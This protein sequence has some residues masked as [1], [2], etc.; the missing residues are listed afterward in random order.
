VTNTPW[1][2]LAFVLQMQFV[3]GSI[4]VLTSDGLFFTAEDGTWT[5]ISSPGS[6]TKK[7]S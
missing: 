7:P 2:P 6:E 5:K 4:Y 1:N 3:H